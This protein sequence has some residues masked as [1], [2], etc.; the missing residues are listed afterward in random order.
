MS[1]GPGSIVECVDVSTDI[2]KPAWLKIFIRQLKLRHLYRVRDVIRYP[3]GGVG[4][5][6]EN[7]DDPPLNW[8]YS[9]SRF[10]PL[11]KGTLEGLT[12]EKV[13]EPCP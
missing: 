3:D 10:R 7:V 5:S 11:E 6:L 2:D 8:R 1:V 4:Y 13:L 12:T 9:A